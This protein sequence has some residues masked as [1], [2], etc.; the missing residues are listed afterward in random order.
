MDKQEL[1]P[2]E[3][4]SWVLDV[5]MLRVEREQKLINIMYKN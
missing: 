2:L 4:C 1:I 3:K 5:S